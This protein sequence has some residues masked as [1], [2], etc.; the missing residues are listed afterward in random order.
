M[1]N[2]IHLWILLRFTRGPS[3]VKAT[4]IQAANDEQHGGKKLITQTHEQCPVTGNIL[5][6]ETF[7][8]AVNVSSASSPQVRAVEKG[9]ILLNSCIEVI[10]FDIIDVKAKKAVSSAFRSL[11]IMHS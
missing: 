7:T 11:P 10:I 4:T 2:I 9:Q 3:F 6:K 5:P 1:Q 8:I